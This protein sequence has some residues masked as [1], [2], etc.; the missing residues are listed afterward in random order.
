[1]NLTLVGDSLSAGN[2]GIPYSSYINIGQAFQVINHGIDGDTVLGVLKRID[3]VLRSTTPQILIIEAG[4]NDI[5][6][7][8]MK[9][10]GGE[11]PAFIDEMIL[12]GSIPAENEAEFESTYSDLLSEISAWGVE[13]II[14]TTIPPLGEGHNSIGDKKRRRLNTIISRLSVDNETVI[15]DVA[16]GFEEAL[17]AEPVRSDWFFSSPSDF[18]TD[19]RR[20]RRD[21]SAE[22]LSSERGLYLTIDGTHLNERGAALMGKIVSEAID[23]S[24]RIDA[25]AN[26]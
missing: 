18:T 4:A 22:N 10:K 7:P 13:K 11:W 20:I 17:E 6:L 1:M 5:L 19:L 15:A 21:K 26:C 24:I 14:C 3:D 16:R 9:Q 2:L 25:Q 12:Q 8:V 23:K